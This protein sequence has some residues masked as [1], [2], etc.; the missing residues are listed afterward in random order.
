MIRF[1]R[2]YLSIAWNYIDIP[3][4][5]LTLLGSIIQILETAI[6]TS[7]SDREFTIMRVVNALAIFFLFLKIL[8]YAR[9]NIE[10]AFMV[11]ML[12]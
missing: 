6:F 1:K 7:F 5:F 4:Y 3:T 12:G 9:A 8:G 10:T 2:I 11:Q